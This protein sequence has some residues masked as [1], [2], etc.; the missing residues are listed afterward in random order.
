MGIYH[1]ALKSGVMTYK[2]VKETSRANHSKG[3]ILK[4]DIISQG[5]PIEFDECD[6]LWA[7]PPW[8]H[9]F[10]VFNE[11]A[12]ADHKSYQNL[13]DAISEIIES[14]DKPI[15]M[16]LCKSL[17]RGLPNADQVEE[18]SLNSGEAL[19]A[20]WNDE[21]VGPYKTTNEIC[22]TLGSIYSCIGDF[23][24]GYG[25]CVVDFI[26]GGG[27]KF[28]ASDFDG[29]CVTVMAARMKKIH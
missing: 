16:P 12:N 7:E 6:F 1:S 17:L 22:Q 14:S 23:T 20:I 8:P 11:R 13:V 28:V 26:E 19:L 24:C 15:Y 3:I 2:D 25:N 4:N 9:G 18:T 27:K 10:K 29:K 5:L 21:Y